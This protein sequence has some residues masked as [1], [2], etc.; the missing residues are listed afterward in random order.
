MKNFPLDTSKEHN[1]GSQVSGTR[2][3]NEATRSS[4]R[5]YTLNNGYDLHTPVHIQLSQ[6]QPPCK[7]SHH[8]SRILLT[9]YLSFMHKFKE[10]EK[11]LERASFLCLRKLQSS[12]KGF[13]KVHGM[14]LYSSISL[15]TLPIP[16]AAAMEIVCLMNRPTSVLPKKREAHF[17]K[18]VNRFVRVFESP[19]LKTENLAATLI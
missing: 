12:Q 5:N 3:A 7:D 9:A 16:A 4:H 14:I 1:F 15:P 17:R 2:E 11:Q 19:N 6:A 10:D 8:F 13:A 18:A